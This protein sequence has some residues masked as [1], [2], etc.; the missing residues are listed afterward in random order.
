MAKYFKEIE[1]AQQLCNRGLRKSADKLLN[2]RM[3]ET[4]F[5]THD[6]KKIITPPMDGEYYFDPEHLC[7]QA[8]LAFLNCIKSLPLCQ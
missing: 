8:R 1:R 2:I 3:N 7:P 5:H 4:N 6:T